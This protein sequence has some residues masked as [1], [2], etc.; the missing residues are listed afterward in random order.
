MRFDLSLGRQVLERTPATLGALL[1]GLDESWTTSAEGPDTWSPHLVMAHLINGERTD[2]IPRVRVFLARDPTRGFA[3][4][5]REG[6]FDEARGMPLAELLRIFEV[7][8]A[9]SLD[10]LDSFQLTPAELALTAR[11]PELGMVTLRQ[12]LAT[13]VAHDLGHIVQITRT[14]ARQYRDEVGPWRR[15]LSA[16]Q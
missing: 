4:F 6:L 12:H 9:Q 3:P 7:E 2:W 8:R 13:W 10:A 14:M 1:D 5:D 15:Y 11:H 16:L